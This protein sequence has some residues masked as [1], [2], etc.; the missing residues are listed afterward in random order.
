[1]KAL[2]L[3]ENMLFTLI[4]F[5]AF[6]ACNNENNSI[7]IEENNNDLSKI[8][9]GTWVQDGDD[10]VIVIKAD[11]HV[12][13]YE[14]ENDYKNQKIHDRYQW[15]LKNEWLYI[16]DQY[17]NIEEMRPKEVHKNISARKDYHGNKDEYDSYGYYSLWTW[18]RYTK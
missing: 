2:K 4:A 13:W 10:D 7:E 1:M 8:L 9:I 12:E 3:I 15:K 14:N 11:G 5:T 18:E 17:E 6:S 16:Y